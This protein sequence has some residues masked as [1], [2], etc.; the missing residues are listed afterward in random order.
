MEILIM[1]I[2]FY[3]TVT[4]AAGSSTVN[5]GLNVDKIIKVS[6]QGEQK[7]YSPFVS[8]STLDGTDWTYISPTK[9]IA[10]GP[11]FPFAT[12]GETIHIIYKL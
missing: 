10:F 9:R 12:G 11:S 8:V 2:L 5:S 1:A 7:D 6:R 4:G 3:K